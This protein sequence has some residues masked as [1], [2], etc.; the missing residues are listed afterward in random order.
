MNPMTNVKNIA[1]L[2]Q[3]EL[4]SDKK[5]SWHDD[6]KES[7]WIFIGGLPYDLTEGDVIAIFSQYGEVVNI[8][9]VRDKDTGKQKGYGFLCYEDQRSTILAVDNLNGIKILGRTI[10]VDHVKDYKAPKI[11]KHIDNETKQLRLEGCAPKI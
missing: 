5:S 11:S 2:G 7:A 1:K 4:G 3:Q 6:Y 8:N 9:L 10:R